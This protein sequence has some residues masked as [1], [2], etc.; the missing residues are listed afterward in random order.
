MASKGYLDRKA[1]ELNLPWYWIPG[2]ERF[3]KSVLPPDPPD[4]P[5]NS[6][7][8]L[9]A[10]RSLTIPH[11]TSTGP[12]SGGCFGYKRPVSNPGTRTHA[13]VDLAAKAGDPVRSVTDGTI[14]SFYKFYTTFRKKLEVFCV[15][16]N[17]GDFV[18][19][20]GE[21][22]PTLPDGL[23]VG[24]SVK[25]GQLIGYVGQLD[26]SAMLHIEMYRPGVTTN[27]RWP[28]FPTE[29]APAG[30]YNPTAFLLTLAGKK[31]SEYPS[32]P[33]SELHADCR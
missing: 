16:V 9:D 20:Y 31:R 7:W 23:A 13:G 15:F 10:K 5:S 26:N 11:F 33:E 6:V 12:N 30:M 1:A 14:V 19:N 27:K 32:P 24:S 17:H 28:G 25:A 8:P 18:I 21:I 3:T 4:P 29:A 22:Q 2:E